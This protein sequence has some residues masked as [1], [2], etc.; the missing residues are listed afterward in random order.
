MTGTSNCTSIYRSHV[1]TTWDSESISEVKLEMYEDGN[2]TVNIRFNG[3][4]SNFTNW[5]D[6][7]RLIDSGWSTMSQNRTFNFFSL[8][9]GFMRTF[10]INEAYKGCPKDRGWMIVIDPNVGYFPCGYEAQ[11]NKPAFLYARGENITR[12]GDND[13]GLADVLAVFIKR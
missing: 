5:F 8:Q 2:M 13:Y 6:H 4:G 7:N 3:T 10:F 11:P 1:L 9:G 12:W